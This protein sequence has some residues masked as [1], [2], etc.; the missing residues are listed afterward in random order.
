MLKLLV[1]DDEATT[2]EG[3]L[4]ILDLKDIGIGM[5]R[6]ADDGING[7]KVAAE[8]EPD[9]VLTDVK[10]P[11]MDGVEMSFKLRE[12]YP[13]CKIIFMSGYSD[14]EYLRSAI[15][16][17]A[18]NYIEKPINLNELSNAIKSAST[19]CIE[20]HASTSLMRNELA[21]QLISRNPDTALINEQLKVARL[22]IPQDGIFITVLI[23][24]LSPG[25]FPPDQANGIKEVIRQTLNNTY[26][27]HSLL[28][29]TAFEDNGHIIIHLFG[30]PFEK[31]LFT[32]EK[33]Q[34]FCVGIS[35]V[36][37]DKCRFFISIGKKVQG[38][39]NIHES[40]ITAVLNMQ[41]AFFRNSGCMIG[42][43]ENKDPPFKFDDQL[44][45]SFKNLITKENQE[46][47]IFFIKRITSDLK[48]S[49]NT[50]VNNSKDFYFRLLLE[51]RK[52]A[53]QQGF[54]LMDDRVEENRLW[55]HFLSFD[56]LARMEEFFIENMNTYF[57][58]LEEKNANPGVVNNI[59]KYVK[60]NY[61]DE[62]L[63][64][65]KISENTHLAPTY[66]C[67]LF[68]EKTGTTLNRYITEYRM[69]KAKEML[70][71]K[72]LK[73][74]DIAEMVGCSGGSYFTK[75]FRK[76]TSLTPT[77]YRERFPL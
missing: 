48:R 23:K 43:Q 44:L 73:I 51:L 58:K 29:M 65:N 39:A 8:F 26:M 11:R 59:I 37:K 56:T 42:Y 25:S 54:E 47:T 64:I 52:E 3:I 62:S 30:K 34:D 67:Y 49:E 41:K 12:L 40:Y 31:H 24:I 66:L 60:N 19:L 55:E 68:K 46:Q 76:A 4:D 22:E 63:S 53:R 28:G 6:Q 72:E 38:L 9:I 45:Q 70:M 7:L 35:D 18:E 14:K 74:S 21:L 20:E 27:H 61:H 69:E 17:K 33:L 75:L 13:H 10:M 5:V 71:D 32:N 50:L 1:V 77:E 2:R 57:K 15:Q 16:L 36:L